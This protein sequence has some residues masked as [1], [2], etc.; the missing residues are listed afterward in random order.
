MD[1]SWEITA[2]LPSLAA[3]SKHHVPT[4]KVK[5]LSVDQNSPICS[6]Q[7]AVKQEA[8]HRY[9]SCYHCM[10]ICPEY[11]R[12]CGILI[13]SNIPALLRKSQ[14]CWKHSSPHMCFLSLSFNKLL[15]RFDIKYTKTYSASWYHWRASDEHFIE[16]R[17]CVL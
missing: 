8:K 1:R 11:R 2:F 12:Q 4:T 13:V 6:S 5:N 10:I 9:P 16:P 14:S 15:L 3:V 17:Y 7:T